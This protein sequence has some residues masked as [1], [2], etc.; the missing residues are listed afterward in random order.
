MDHD[1]LRNTEEVVPVY[2]RLCFDVEHV[3]LKELVDS[4]LSKNIV[5]LALRVSVVILCSFLFVLTCF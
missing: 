1:L 4:T 2:G 5:G 3:T